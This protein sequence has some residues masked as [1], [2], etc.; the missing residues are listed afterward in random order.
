MINKIAQAVDASDYEYYG[1]R[2]DDGA[3]YSVG[4]YT[5]DSRIWIDGEPTGKTLDGTSA[6]GFRFTASADEIAAAVDLASIY[7]GN[8]M[9]LLGSNS[10]E[11]GE[12]A[13]EYIMH[14]AVVVA[15]LK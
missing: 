10:I 15:I 13:G 5:A 9:Y 7:Y 14:D 4:D 3:N 2:I 11:Y 12:D 1:I 8:R 6:V